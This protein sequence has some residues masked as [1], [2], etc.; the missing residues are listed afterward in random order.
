MKRR[1]EHSHV[2][3]ERWLVSY[4]DFITLLFAFFVVMYAISSVNE[5][6]YKVLSS[7][8]KNVFDT[9]PASSKPIALLHGSASSSQDS[10][11]KDVSDEQRRVLVQIKLDMVSALKNEMA[12]HKVNIVD[13]KDWLD[14][15][16][17]SELLFSSGS[18][19][20]SDAALTTLTKIS[21]VL[22]RYPNAVRIQGYT[23]NVPIVSSIYPSNWELSAA[24]AVSV[25]RLFIEQGVDPA[26]MAA[27]AYGEF[28]PLADNTT[29]AGRQRNRRVMVAIS[30]SASGPTSPFE[31]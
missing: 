1:S 14:I 3:H 25:L 28:Q 29:E 2:N 8:L 11:Q 16:I 31:P 21:Q 22:A 23:D 30:K 4:A 18:A 5:G 13:H 6:K 27:V 26:R 9:A 12:Q 10:T 7:T 20:L 17:Q 15:D 19:V 24:R